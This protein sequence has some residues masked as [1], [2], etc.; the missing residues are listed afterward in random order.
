[1]LRRLAILEDNQQLLEERIEALRR[2]LPSLVAGRICAAMVIGSVAAGRARDSSD[3]DLLVVLREGTPQRADYD[4][5]DR[6][7]AP[8]VGHRPGERFPVAPVIVGRTAIG[9]SEP[10]LR[11]ALAHGIVLWDPHSVFQ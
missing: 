8:H 4:W 9:T 1:M 7:V 6:E 5:W 11:E 3:I 2:D 10:N